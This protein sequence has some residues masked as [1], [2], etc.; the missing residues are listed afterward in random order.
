[1]QGRVQRCISWVFPHPSNLGGLVGNPPGYR[2]DGGITHT[3]PSPGAAAAQT[4]ASRRCPTPW[5]RAVGRLR[6]RI[7]CAPRRHAVR[8]R[9]GIAEGAGPARADGL[10]QRQRLSVGGG[11]ERDAECGEDGGNCRASS[12]SR[13][14]C[15]GVRTRRETNSSPETG[16]GRHRD[17]ACP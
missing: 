17:L 13:R 3:P 5:A 1:V 16:S 4:E 6:D 2:A 12:K 11:A 7:R 10:G 9:C 15:N 8:S 14:F